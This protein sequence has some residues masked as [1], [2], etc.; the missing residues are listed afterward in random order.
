M[1]PELLALNTEI[2]TILYAS[3]KRSLIAAVIVAVLLLFILRHLIQHDFLAM[4]AIIFL[5][6]YSVRLCITHQY[7]K[8]SIERHEVQIWLNRFRVSTGL[9]GLVWGLASIFLFPASDVGHQIFLIFVLVG[10]AGAAMVVYSIDTLCSNLFIGGVLVLMV[11]QFLIHGSNLA[12]TF[13][14]LAI[15]YVIYV[16]IAG[17]GLAKNLHKNIALSIALNIDNKKV[18]QLAYY[19]VLTNLPNRRLLTDSLNQTFI[20][21][22]R[23]LSYGAVLFLDLNNFKSLNDTKGHIAG[24]E[25][26]Q[27]VARRLKYTLSKKEMVAR[28]G[29][30]EF[31]VVLDNLGQDKASAVNTSYLMAEKLIYTISQPFQLKNFKYHTTP[32]IGICLFLGHEFDETEVLRRA[33]LAMYQAKQAQN[34]NCVQLYDEERYPAIELRAI[35]ENDLSFALHGQQFTLYY[36]LQVQQ[37]QK[38]IGAEVLLRWHHPTLGSISPNDFISIAETSGAIVPIGNWVLMQACQQLKL[39]ENSAMTDYLTLSVNVSALQFS[40]PD[41][42]DL[43]IKVVQSTGCKPRLLK[44]ELTE[45]LMVRNMDDVVSK[46]NTLKAIGIK[47]SLDDFGIGQS[48][49]SVLRKLPLDE[50]KIDRSF[51]SEI[52]Q[53]NYDKVIVQTI[54]S[55]GR[56][57]GCHVIAEGVEVSQQKNLL[58]SL[59]CHAYQGFLFSKPLAIEVFE[60][61]L[62]DSTLFEC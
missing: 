12:I 22:Q 16:R 3:N 34:V 53:N 23:T 51:I 19:D 13:I 62:T 27:L 33:D 14:G 56:L 9:C 61:K 35:L 48:S 46:I 49:L 59:G 38:P 50:I 18:H 47:F 52:L 6:A 20:K 26:L 24:D 36:Q 11:P 40:Q 10:V 45:S 21:C 54:I 37:D 28:I 41:F 31:V 7:Y 32:S 39:W 57:L 8:H 5:V 58:E 44:L 17:H 2:A 25:L 1:T 43:V 55:M 4:W 60:T 15:V 42:T 29:G 30:D